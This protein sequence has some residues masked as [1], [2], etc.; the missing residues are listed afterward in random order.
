MT[1]ETVTDLMTYGLGVAGALCLLLALFGERSIDWME[2]RREDRRQREEALQGAMKQ[3]RHAMARKMI[4]EWH[5]A[6]HY[7][8]H[9]LPWQYH[10]NEER[11]S[12]D[13]N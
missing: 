3:R 8:G 2:R 13:G 5:A 6:N 7:H 4:D 1:A 10:T 12:D 11:R 9:H